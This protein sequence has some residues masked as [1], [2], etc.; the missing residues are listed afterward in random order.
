MD[1]EGILKLD[2]KKLFK[3]RTE[4]QAPRKSRSQFLNSA[5]DNTASSLDY[6]RSTLAYIMV[7]PKTVTSSLLVHQSRSNLSDPN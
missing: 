5:L 4:G 3:T 1:R 7:S 6:D 2:R